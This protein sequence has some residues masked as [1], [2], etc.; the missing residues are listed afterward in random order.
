MGTA[1]LVGMLFRRSLRCLASRRASQASRDVTAA[2]VLL[3]S[4]G[5]S[6]GAASEA[7]ARAIVG[8]GRDRRGAYGAR[9][10]FSSYPVTHRC[11]A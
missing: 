4:I 6:N 7:M 11:T 2:L 3:R 1:L 8:Q 5:N 9:H 10:R